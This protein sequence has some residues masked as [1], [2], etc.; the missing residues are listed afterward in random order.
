MRSKGRG[1][2]RDRASEGAQFGSLRSKRSLARLY[3]SRSLR[4]APVSSLSLRVERL[5][6]EEGRLVELPKIVSRKTRLRGREESV[7]TN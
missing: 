3:S 5:S 4:G 1:Q 7:R 6:M 2:R